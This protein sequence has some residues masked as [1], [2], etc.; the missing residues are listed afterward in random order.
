MFNYI[1]KGFFVTSVRRK[2][3]TRFDYLLRLYTSCVAIWVLYSAIFSRLDVLAT[4]IIY[5][6][7]ILVPSFLY[8]G[9]SSRSDA[10][11]PSV[12]DWCLA[13]S[14]FISA[15]YFRDRKYRYKDFLTK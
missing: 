5:L 12:I 6:C 2:V 7:L 14:A 10:K 15:I 3:V 4:S 13:F 1:L 9:G 8:I 11:I